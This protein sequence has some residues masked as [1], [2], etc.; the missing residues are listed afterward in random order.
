MKRRYRV[1]IYLFCLILII[2]TTFSLTWI[3][4]EKISGDTDIYKY[5]VD[6]KEKLYKDKKY[7]YYFGPKD[8]QSKLIDYNNA[9]IRKDKFN[10]YK[11]VVTL[12]DEESTLMKNNYFFYKNYL[13]LIAGN[14]TRFNLGAEKIMKTKKV[15]KGCFIGNARVSKIFGQKDGFIYFKVKLFKESDNR[16]WYEDRYYKLKYDNMK[17]YEIPQQLLP[18]FE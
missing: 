11:I 4:L 13:Y 14:I 12:N 7:T 6:F 15:D 17:L 5:N 9:V 1:L 8:E 16:N 3:F 2:L 18:E 10:K